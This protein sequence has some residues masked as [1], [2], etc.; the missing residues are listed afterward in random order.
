MSD[1]GRQPLGISEY[2]GCFNFVGGVSG[3]CM[4][5]YVYDDICLCFRIIRARQIWKTARAFSWPAVFGKGVQW[6]GCYYSPSIFSFVFFG[7]KIII[8][9]LAWIRNG[10]LE[11]SIAHGNGNGNNCIWILLSGARVGWVR[12][13]WVGTLFECGQNTPLEIGDVILLKGRWDIYIFFFSRS[14]SQKIDAFHSL[15]LRSA[16]TVANSHWL[17]SFY[18]SC[19]MDLFVLHSLFGNSRRVQSRVWIAI[20]WVRKTLKNSPGCHCCFLGA[21]GSGTRGVGV[22]FR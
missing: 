11:G 15:P 21:E 10:A 4:S 2:Q 9:S 5:M 22:Y 6:R 1:F 3:S 20:R 16:T 18:D 17:E 19:L 14:I 7:S 8:P 13:G 12:L